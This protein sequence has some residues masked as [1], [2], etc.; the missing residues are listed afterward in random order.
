MKSDSGPK[1]S[2]PRDLAGI[3]GIYWEGNAW[4]EVLEATCATQENVDLGKICPVYACARERGVTHC[5]LCPEFPC[6]LLVNLAAEGGPDDIRI[7]SA[8]KRAEMGDE[9]WAEWARPRKIWARALCP[10]RNIQPSART[11]AGG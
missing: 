1:G 7:E 3:C 4:Y 8:A 10:L 9:R 6:A 5:G 2:A 11:R